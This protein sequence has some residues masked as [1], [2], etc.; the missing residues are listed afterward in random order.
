MV[1]N[2]ESNSFKQHRN[3]TEYNGFIFLYNKNTKRNEGRS[4]INVLCAQNRIT[5]LLPW[6]DT[7]L[8]QIIFLIY[9][10]GGADA[11]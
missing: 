10:T 9:F 4:D 8:V 5:F 11:V 2:S 7:K 3:N 1:Y 6:F